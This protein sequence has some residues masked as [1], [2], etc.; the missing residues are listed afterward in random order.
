M[1]DRES[2]GRDR[3]DASFLQSAHQL[4]ENRLA[5]VDAEREDFFTA[6]SLLQS[7]DITGAVEE[8]RRATRTSGAPFDALAMVA[9]GECQ[10]LRGKEAAA[11]R[12]WKKIANDQSA[13]HAARYVAWLSLARVAEARED[14]QLLERAN[15]ALEEI[16][17]DDL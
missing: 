9:L 15:S 2:N 6:L 5:D 12:E 14:D 8:F 4:V 16:S 17:V 10:R 7:G 11:I 1:N 13:P 3:L